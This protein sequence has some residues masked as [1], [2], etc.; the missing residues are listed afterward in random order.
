MA[1][2]ERLY[3]SGG[4]IGNKHVV[5]TNSRKFEYLKQTVIVSMNFL[6]SSHSYNSQNFLIVDPVKV[7]NAI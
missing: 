7:S 3:A 5:I 1:L 2:Y 4:E 6:F